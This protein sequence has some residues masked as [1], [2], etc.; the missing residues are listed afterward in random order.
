[1]TTIQS[2]YYVQ[3]HYD[4]FAE[5]GYLLGSTRES[6]PFAFVTGLME[7]DPPGLGEHLLGKPID[8]HG[9]IILSPK[10]G[11]GLALPP[12]QSLGQVDLAS[13][14]ADFDVQK[15]QMFEAEFPGQG[16]VMCTIMD[17]QGEQV[18][19]FYGHPL[20]GQ[21][22]HFKVEVISAQ[23]A[24]QEDISKIQQLYGFNP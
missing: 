7:T 8:F 23:P 11:Y 19:V 22:L 9:D 12:E 18:T 10:E 24:T 5:D 13:F 6:A 2:N 20:A 1:M 4:L 16:V 14:P 15:G 17:V 3:I 21:T